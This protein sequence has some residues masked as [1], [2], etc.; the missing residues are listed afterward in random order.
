MGFLLKKT[1]STFLMPLSLG[2]VLLTIGLFYL[3]KS[4]R[5]RGRF[6]VTLGVVWLTLFSYPPLA[7]T[8]LYPLEHRYP[9][10]IQAPQKVRYI[11][12]LGYGHTTDATLP[13]TSQLEEEA[14]VRLS[15]GIR[16]YRQLQG[17]AK[18]ILSG[19]SGLY[20]PTSHA[21]MQQRLARALGVA[22]EDIILENSPKDTQ[23]EALA[24]K[25]VVGNEALILVTSA[26]HMPRAM[27]WFEKVDLH[28]LPAPTYHQASLKHV[29]YFDIFSICA[30]KKSTIV[31][32]EYLGM[33]W[34]ALK[35]G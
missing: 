17:K 15:E 27:R 18:L 9:S 26:Y 3:F 23:E 35:G 19:Y 13:I 32:H 33:V 16:L 28:P 25:R 8:L 2:I 29:H 6:F 4:Q 24:A 14:V 7:N 11:Y 31:F 10:L 20:D 34:Q 1:V 30:L 21:R 5:K 22:A 12:V